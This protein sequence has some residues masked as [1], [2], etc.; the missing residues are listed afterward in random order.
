M[1]ELLNCA[2]MRDIEQRTMG[3]GF[4]SGLDLM[5]RAGRGVVE[6]DHVWFNLDRRI[7]G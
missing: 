6:V 1:D 5:E 3:T 4:S 7:G 2:Q